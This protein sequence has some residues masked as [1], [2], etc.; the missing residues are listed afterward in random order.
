V[1]FTHTWEVLKCS[2]GEEWGPIVWEKEVLLGAKEERGTS[3]VRR[4]KGRPTGLVVY[5][6]GTAF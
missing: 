1:W 5:C 4:K 3:Y 6:V 2:I